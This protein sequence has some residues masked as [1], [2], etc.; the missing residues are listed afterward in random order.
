MAYDDFGAKSRYLR[1]VDTCLLCQSLHIWVAEIVENLNQIW[2]YIFKKTNG[3]NY[4][5]I[6]PS[7]PDFQ[8][9]EYHEIATKY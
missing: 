6:I 3:E 7:W 1:H 9:N 8:A 4:I 5:D 2:E